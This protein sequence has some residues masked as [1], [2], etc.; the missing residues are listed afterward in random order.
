M[1]LLHSHSAE[2]ASS[3]LDLW[4]LPGSQ[5]GAFEGNYVHYQPISPIEDSS[6]VEFSIPGNSS[7]YFDL[8]HCLL[9]VKCK[10]VTDAGGNLPDDSDAAPVNNLLHSMWSQCDVLLNNKLVSQSGHAYNYRA[11]ITNHLGFGMEAKDTH[12]TSG[13]WF[14]DTAGQHDILGEANKGYVTRKKMA[15]NSKTI[16]LLG[17]I[18]SDIFNQDRFLLNSVQ[19]QLKFYRAKDSFVLMSSGNEKL[20]LLEARLIVRK[21]K[22]A[23]DILLAHMKALEVS[24]CKL[25]IT[26]VELKSFTLSTGLANKTIELGSGSVP[27]RL[28]LGLVSNKA[29]N[30]DYKSN[31]LKFHHFKLNFLALYLDSQQ[32][33]SQPLTPDFSSGEYLESYY[34]LFNGTGIH[35][36]DCGSAIGRDEYGKGS[37]LWAFDT[38]PTLTASQSGWDLQ[39]QATLRIDVRF[40]EALGEAVNLIVLS[41]YDSLIQI[42]KQRNVIVDYST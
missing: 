19:M 36:G 33:P 26:R 18:H 38:T 29:F 28:I 15:K 27:K 21:V 31:G 10:V 3:A 8:A 7:E 30:G 13:F 14:E 17:G 25:P 2:S 24:P 37:T 16:E 6:C 5:A 4:A 1:S 41:E 11:F 9:Y 32:I 42:D 22:I 20:K 35:F 39:K 40:A 34:T 12:L 23:P